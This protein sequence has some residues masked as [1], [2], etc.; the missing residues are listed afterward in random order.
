MI[1]KLKI[2]I[3]TESRN[4]SKQVLKKILNL[5]KKFK[6]ILV[7]SDVKFKNELKKIK[8]KILNG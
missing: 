1:N 7:V 8:L 3:F 5:K 6:I 2:A 4:L